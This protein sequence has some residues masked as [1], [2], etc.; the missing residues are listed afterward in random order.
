MVNQLI[1]NI[2]LEADKHWG[3][4][5]PKKQYLSSYIMKRFLYEFPIDLYVHLGDQFDTK[6]LLNSKP[7]VYAIQDFQEKLAICKDRNIKVRAIRGT[8]SHDYDQWEVFRKFENDNFKIFIQNTVEE[9]LPNMTCIY[10]P[11]ENINTDEYIDRYHDN[12]FE[13][14]IDIGF[15]HGSF[16]VV[17]PRIVT[18]M[19]ED[20][21]STNLVFEYELWSSLIKG[22]LLSGHWHDGS[23][24]GSLIYIGSYDRWAFAEDEVKGF[25]IVQYNTETGEY[26]YIKVPNFFAE[27]YKTY[28]VD[29]YIYNIDAYNALS[30]L[31]DSELEL[32]SNLK[33][34]VKINVTDEK[35]ENE[36]LIEAFRF[37]YA[38][39]KKVKITVI[40]KLQVEKKKKKK[41][42]ETH[43]DSVYGYI[44]DNSISYPEK[45]GRYITTM[46]GKQYSLEEIEKFVNKYLPD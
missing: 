24:Y 32:D 31:I 35:P 19:S 4:M 1:Y 17:L 46:T 14:M 8:R 10:C 21:L 37:Y 44:R 33:I 7:A 23:E 9:T 27:N 16:D 40:N 2:L 45:I 41:K 29:T 22:P 3:A 26:K 28:I 30:Q 25:G 11:D 6:L 43:M 38:N 13:N 34:R 20:S 39:S 18:Q 42:E 15:F 12:I 5:S 36:T